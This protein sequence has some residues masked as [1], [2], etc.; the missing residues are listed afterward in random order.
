MEKYLETDL[1][2]KIIGLAFE[3]QNKIGKDYPERI[4]QKALAEKFTENGIKYIMES[5]C[6]V[7]IDGHRVGSFK[8]DFLVEGKVVVELKARAQIFQ[9]D[10]SQVL[11][12]L[13]VKHIK[14]GLILLFAPDKVEIK[15]L[16][17]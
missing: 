1:T 17:L 15:R 6:K 16:V 9:K 11:T 3:V 13:R 5:Y 14:L 10:I 2:S 8:L 4:Y 12:Y 7:E